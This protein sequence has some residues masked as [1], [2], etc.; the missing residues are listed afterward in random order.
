MPFRIIDK[1]KV[2]MTN[3]EWNM[4]ESIC[5]SYDD[6]NFKGL[7]LFMDLFET[8]DNGIIVFLRPPSTRKTSFEVFLFLM[9]LMTNQH[10][11]SIHKQVDE[12]CAEVKEKI[13]NL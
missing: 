4:Y 3:D 13:K 1:K 9:S 11:R 5:R 10:L 6:I 8:D 2:E 12:L 7:E